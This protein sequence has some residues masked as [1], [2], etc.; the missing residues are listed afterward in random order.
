MLDMVFALPSDYD[1]IINSDEKDVEKYKTEIN[2]LTEKWENH[3]FRLNLVTKYSDF[4]RVN[5]ALYSMKE[6]FFTGYYTDYAVMR[7]RLISALEKQKQNELPVLENI[8]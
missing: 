5:T 1:Y 2:K 3:S 4:E 6:Y 7:K 8:F